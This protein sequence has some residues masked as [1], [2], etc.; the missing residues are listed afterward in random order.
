MHCA[1]RKSKDRVPGSGVAVLEKTLKYK[2]SGSGSYYLK[3]PN[4]TLKF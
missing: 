4:C 2:V 1:S 3:K